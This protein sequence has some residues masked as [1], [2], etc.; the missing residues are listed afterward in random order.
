MTLVHPDFR[1][2]RRNFGRGLF[3]ALAVPGIVSAMAEM[4]TQSR[5]QETGDAD[6]LFAELDE[7]IQLGMKEFAI[8]G[9]AVGVIYNGQEFVKGYGFTDV[10]HPDPQHSVDTNTTFR[11]ASVSK[12]ITGTAAMR[13]VELGMLDLDAPVTRYIQG[14]QAPV[15]AGGVTVRQLLNHSAGW[16]GDVFNNTGSGDDAVANYVS[17]IH[18]LPQLTPP[19]LVFAYNNAALITSGRVIEEVTG[20]TFES[21][22]QNLV[23]GPL[24]MTRSA[25]F[26]KE[27]G[28]NVAIPHAVENGQ[29]VARPEDLFLPRNQGPTGG[30]IASVA[31]MLSFV[32]LFLEDGRGANGKRLM[33]KAAAESMWSQP[34]PGGTLGTELKGMGVAWQTRPTIE[35]LAVVQH[36]GD[37]PG[38]RPQLL[39]VP[40]KQFGIVLLTNSD[41]GSQLR[42]QLFFSNWVLQRFANVR[43]IPASTTPL[44]ASELAQYEGVYTAITINRENKEEQLEVHLAAA[45]G[46]LELAGPGGLRLSL[47]FYGYDRVTSL[48]G[49]RSDFLRAGDGSIQ[50]FRFSGRLYRPAT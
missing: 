31:D 41:G 29:A 37:L 14:F 3:G 24:G 8:P 34:G 35:G 39:T 7:K 13:L 17:G 33:S 26:L 15:G 20:D 12:P 40:Q 10:R 32:R 38:F 19:G 48:D 45:N 25:F 50:W 47:G 23:L 46:G 44:S 27:L 42:A 28:T 6:E 9:A 22:L 11:I 21:A 16:L 18:R 2:S 5:A 49:F 1:L 4:P 36:S 30:V 43:D